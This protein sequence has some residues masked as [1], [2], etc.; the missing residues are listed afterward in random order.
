MG[1]TKVENQG[2]RIFEALEKSSGMT[3]GLPTTFF[4]THELSFRIQF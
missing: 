4:L 2:R 1:F 3:L